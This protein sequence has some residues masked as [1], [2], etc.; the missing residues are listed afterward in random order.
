MNDIIGNRCKFTMIK[1]IIYHSYL[2][3]YLVLLI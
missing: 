2:L 1:L 3:I